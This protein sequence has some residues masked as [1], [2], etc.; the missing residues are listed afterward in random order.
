VGWLLAWEEPAV[1]C[2]AGRDLLGERGGQAAA[3]DADPI[4]HGPKDRA[5]LAGQRPDGGL[6]VAY[7]KVDQAHWRLVGALL[8]RTCKRR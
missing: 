7:R 5:L 8:W 3:A 6:G 1:R 4:L 2:L